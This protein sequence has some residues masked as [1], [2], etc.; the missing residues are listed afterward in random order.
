M[1]HAFGIVLATAILVPRSEK[2][3]DIARVFIVR[4]L[5][6]LKGRFRGA[7]EPTV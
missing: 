4:L 1:L 2:T 7:R 3:F 5:I 6:L